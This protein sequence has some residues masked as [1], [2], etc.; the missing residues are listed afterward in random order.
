VSEVA[1]AHKRID[2]ALRAEAR[3]FDRI[4]KRNKNQHKNEED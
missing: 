1:R 4:D 2:D 3:E